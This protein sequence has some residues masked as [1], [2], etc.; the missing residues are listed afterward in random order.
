MIQT[1]KIPITEHTPTA[2]SFP[3]IWGDEI[4]Q[5]THEMRMESLLCQYDLCAIRSKYEQIALESYK[6]TNDALPTPVQE[7]MQYREVTEA[8][9]KVSEFISNTIDKVN[10]LWDKFSNWV[11]QIIISNKSFIAKYEAKELTSRELE[12]YDYDAAFLQLKEKAA[13]ANHI[14]NAFQDLS[15]GKI[16]FDTDLSGEDS[17]HVRDALARYYSFEFSNTNDFKKKFKEALLPVRY[18]HVVDGKQ[19]LEKLKEIDSF[20]QELKEFTAGMRNTLRKLQA[21]LSKKEDYMDKYGKLHINP[22]TIYD[23]GELASFESREV[24]DATRRMITQLRVDI[25]KCVA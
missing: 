10:L 1:Y 20:Q 3:S 22:Q 6:I 21:Y 2:L 4:A 15:D 9:E 12:T 23:L 17:S 16:Q 5:L 18:P 13:I 11:K 8:F 19:L 24:I 14:A 25:A 7:T